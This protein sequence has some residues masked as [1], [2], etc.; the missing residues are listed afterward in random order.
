[1]IYT[2]KRVYIIRNKKKIVHLCHRLG[3]VGVIVNVIVQIII[4]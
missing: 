1:M 2:M 3:R 4:V